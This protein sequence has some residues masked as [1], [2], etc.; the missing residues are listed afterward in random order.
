MGMGNQRHA[1]AALFPPK[2]LDIY[3]MGGRV[4]LRAVLN[5]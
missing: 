4:V 3:K 1:L 5:V 2:D